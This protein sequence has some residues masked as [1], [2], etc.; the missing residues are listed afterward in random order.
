M[1]CAPRRGFN[2]PPHPRVPGGGSRILGSVVLVREVLDD[3]HDGVHMLLGIYA[4]GL[5]STHLDTWVRTRR[6]THMSAFLRRGSR[7]SMR[8]LAEPL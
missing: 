8:S 2:T 7:Y 3:V 5:V 4:V 1:T 6:G